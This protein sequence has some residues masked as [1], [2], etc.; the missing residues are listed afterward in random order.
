MLFSHITRQFNLVIMSSM[1]KYYTLFV[2]S[3]FLIV[4]VV[5]N[6]SLWRNYGFPNQT[7]IQVTRQSQNYLLRLVRQLTDGKTHYSY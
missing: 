3:I 5:F 2:L 7:S 6:Y 4:N 1:K